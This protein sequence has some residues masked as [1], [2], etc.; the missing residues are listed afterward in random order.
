MILEHTGETWAKE[1][2]ER[3][4]D[5]CIRTMAD[6]GHGVWRQA[7]D[8]FGKNKQRPGITIY[9]KDN[10]HQIRY[11]MMNLLAL[12]QMIKNKGKIVGI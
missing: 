10:F 12:E 11:Q 8:R 1:F 3:T 6:T 4:R 7:V 5:Y 2:Y 9:R